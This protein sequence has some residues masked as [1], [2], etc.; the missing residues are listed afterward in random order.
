MIYNVC[1]SFGVSDMDLQKVATAKTTLD[2]TKYINYDVSRL[3]EEYTLWARKTVSARNLFVTSCDN[4]RVS[5]FKTCF[6]PAP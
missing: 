2:V 5:Q 4:E 6:A 3:D 1:Y